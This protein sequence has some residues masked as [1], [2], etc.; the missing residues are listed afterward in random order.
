MVLNQIAEKDRVSKEDLFNQTNSEEEKRLLNAIL[1]SLEYDGYISI[2]AGTYSFNSPIL[3][4]W[5]NKY[6][7]T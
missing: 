2:T 4:F 1:E 5:W 7:S 3:Q 6:I